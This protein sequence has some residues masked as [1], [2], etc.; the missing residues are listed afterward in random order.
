[1]TR[2][3]AQ[4]NIARLRHPPG[5]PRVAEFTTNTARVNA[6]AE[7]SPGFIWRW[8]DDSAQVL[9]DQPYQAADAD[10]SLAI[11]MSV[12]DGIPSFRHFVHKT[13][14]GAFLRRRDEWFLPWD[15]PNYVL[16]HASPG[17][18]PTLEEGHARLARLARDGAGPEV[19]DLASAS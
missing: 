1:M 5:D 3:L 9:P 16:W 13:L 2:H 4:F 15:G 12:W 6:I 18:V 7:R 19:F 8:A 11:S 10:P 17:T 14:H